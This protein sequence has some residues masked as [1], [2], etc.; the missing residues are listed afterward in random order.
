MSN[1]QIHKNNSNYTIYASAGCNPTPHCADWGDNGLIVFGA[2]NSVAVLDPN[3][4]NSARQIATYTGHEGRVNTVHWLRSSTFQPET[5]FISGADDSNAIVWKFDKQAKNVNFEPLK[6]DGPVTD[7]SSRQLENNK[8]LIAAAAEQ[9]VT[10]WIF[11]TIKITLAQKIIN[12]NSYTLGLCLF[13]LPKSDQLLLAFGNDKGNVLIWAQDKAFES[14]NTDLDPFRM[15]HQMTGHEDWIRALDAVKDGDDILLASSAQDNFIRLWRISKRSAEQARENSVDICN[16]NEEDSEEIRVEEKIIHLCANNWCAIS[17]ESVLYGH[18]GWVYGVNWHRSKENDLRLLSVS[19]DKSIII[20][21]PSEDGVWMEQVRVGEVGGNSLGFYGGKFS[22]N[23]KSIFGHSYQG[24]FHIWHQ[25]PES[26]NLWTPGIIVGGHFDEVRDLAWAPNGEY[27]LTVSADQTSRI[28]APWRRSSDEEDAAVTWH[29]LARP[30]VHGYDMQTLAILSRYKFASGAEEKIVRTFQA[31]TNFIENF[32]RITGAQA[33][34]EGDAVLKNLPK[35]A[36]V[37]S[38]GLSNKAVYSADIDTVPQQKHIK[39]EYPENYFVPVT[40]DAPPQE[41]TLMQN[42]LWPEMQKLYGHGFEIYSLAATP[43]GKVLASACRATNEEHAQIIL[44]DTTTWK[45][46][47]KLAGHK[48]TVTQLRFSPD[49]R[50]LLS[51]SRD[52]T[53]TLFERVEELTVANNQPFYRIKQ[54]SA[55]KVS[56]HSRIIWACDWSHDSKY[57]LTGGRDAVLGVWTQGDAEKADWGLCLKETYTN[58]VTALG[59][60]PELVTT[61][62]YQIAIGFSNGDI[63]LQQL[64]EEGKTLRAVVESKLLFEKAHDSTVKRLQFQPLRDSNNDSSDYFLLAS[65]GED[66]F[67]RIFKCPKAIE[68]TVVDA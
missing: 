56:V 59:F 33:D 5:Y 2:H 32:R 37:P 52:R 28:H 12:Q 11:D 17:L 7:L 66:H 63:L 10:L 65:C 14:N 57:F 35:G 38:L 39:D 62:V 15:V 25:S 42:T 46:I 53:W 67:V 27:L 3:Y 64:E 19:I 51:V 36:S 44:W 34:V 49:S 40:L 54:K 16:I 23:G 61:G 41:E 48:L 6:H 45:Q 21:A 47:Q 18:E 9:T 8:W 31:S 13:Q 55:P 1:I 60:A 26:D 22:S 4:N 30:Q 58:P 29:E 24:G 43:D 68:A 50:L 20:W